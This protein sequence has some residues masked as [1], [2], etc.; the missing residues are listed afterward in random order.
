MTNPLIQPLR[1]HHVSIA[2]PDLEVAIAWYCRTFGFELLK[3]IAIP[4]FAEGAFVGADGIRIELWCAERVTDVP[5][6]RRVPNQDLLT[7]GTKHVAYAVSSL[8]DKLALFEKEGVDIA[9]VV[10]KP[11]YAVFIRDPFGTLIE[12][13]EDPEG[14]QL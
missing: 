14:D 3:R 7:A 9:M 4:E 12:L 1:H 5:A 13:I 2:V 10:P 6:E 8:K 11:V